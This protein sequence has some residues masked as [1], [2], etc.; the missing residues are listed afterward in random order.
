ML[1]QEAAV[2]RAKAEGLPVPTFEPLIATSQPNGETKKPSPQ[3]FKPT[4]TMDQLSP[5]IR[6]QLNKRLEGLTD[7][8]RELE[9]KAIAGEIAAGE[10][11]AGRLTDIY[12]EQERARKERKE[13]GKQTLGDSIRGLFGF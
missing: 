11:L 3:P 4:L 2:E 6:A 12:K 8:E 7:K 9:E 10:L 1:D 13:Q 5:D